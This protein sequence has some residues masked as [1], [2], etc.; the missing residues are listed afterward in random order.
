MNANREH[1]PAG[2]RPARKSVLVLSAAAGLV[3]IGILV[4]SSRHRTI[5]VVNSAQNTG[6]Q[7]TSEATPA[8][9]EP[10]PAA[11]TPV[12]AIPV[13]TVAPTNSDPSAVARELVKRISEIEM[14]PDGI[15]PESATKWRQNLEGLI[16]QGKAAIGPL[17]QFFQSK[18][19]VRFDSGKTNLLGEPTLR[20]AFMKVLS[21]IPTP[22]NVD[23]Q[24]RLLR[25]T[26]DPAEVALLAQQLEA[27][28]PGKYQ[29]LIIYQ[30]KI[31]L[32]QANHGQWPGRDTAPLVKIINASGGAN[33]Q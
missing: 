22:D 2:Q 4:V 29:G 20:I 8:A 24:E 1:E 19:D 14:Q 13:T 15:T 28:E 16:E 32:D 33:A 10:I 12:E 30:A 27:Q 9:P 17:D 21:D 26:S 6:T 5:P 23:L 3:A 25:D 31:S 7:Q 11:S 18:V